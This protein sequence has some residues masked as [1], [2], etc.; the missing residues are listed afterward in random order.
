MSHLYI[1]NFIIYN[2]KQKKKENNQIKKKEKE[3]KKEK[4]LYSFFCYTS[5]CIIILYMEKLFELL[6]SCF[7][8]VKIIKLFL[9]SFNCKNFSC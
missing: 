8:L 1:S 5:I 2:S 4:L 9:I 6:N 7:Q 3:K